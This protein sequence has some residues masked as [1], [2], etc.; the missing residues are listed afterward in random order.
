MRTETRCPESVKIQARTSQVKTGHVRKG[1]EGR[2][3]KDRTGQISSS[4][5]RTGPDR[6]N[7]VKSLTSTL[8]AAPQSH[9]LTQL[10]NAILGTGCPEK[11]APNFLLNISSYKH[12]KRRDP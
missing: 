12:W 5:I 6:L 2:I 3:V 1:D 9:F 11:N 7:Q 4:P 8:G 10:N